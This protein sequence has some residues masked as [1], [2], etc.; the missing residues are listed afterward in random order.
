ML[1]PADDPSPALEETGEEIPLIDDSPVM[2][3]LQV[4][5]DSGGATVSS[6]VQVRQT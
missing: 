3:G 4:S 6:V 5:L 1:E 2:E